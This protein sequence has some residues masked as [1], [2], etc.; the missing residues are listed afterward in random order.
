VVL[1]RYF[2]QFMLIRPV[3]TEGLKFLVEV[4]GRMVCASRI[5]VCEGSLYSESVNK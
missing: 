3:M 1:A 2:F 5:V 4:V